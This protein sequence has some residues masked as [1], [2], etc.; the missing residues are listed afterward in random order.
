MSTDTIL[1]VDDERNIRLTVGQALGKLGVIVLEAVTGEEALDTLR[2]ERVSVVLLDLK[3]PGID[4]MEVLRRLRELG[5]ETKVVIITA[6]GTIDNAVEAMKLGAVDFIQKPFTPDEIR[7]I[8]QK[9]LKRKEGFFK[10][11]SFER[12]VTPEMATVPQAPPPPVPGGESFDECLEQTKAAIER[13][14][15]DGALPWIKK[16]IS[17]DPSRPEG[18]NIIGVLLE[19]KNDWLQAQKFYRAALSIDPTYEPASRNLSRTTERSPGEVLDI[20]AGR[21][22]KQGRRGGGSLFRRKRD[23]NR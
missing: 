16:G 15:F 8:T 1:V 7:Q 5:K 19:I 9:A 23:D 4:G 6:H 11:I 10:R 12:E 13:L 3:M 2:K 21:K 22:P 14:D 20:G 18:Y 17:V